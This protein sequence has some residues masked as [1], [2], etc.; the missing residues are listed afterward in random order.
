MPQALINLKILLPYQIFSENSQVSRV[1]AETRDGSFGILPHRLDCVAAL[2]PGILT[3][4]IQSEKEKYV[5]IDEGILIK[6]GLEVQV[7]VRIAFG[8]TDLAELR[9]EVD[10]EFLDLNDQEKSVRSILAKMEGG[11]MRRLAEFQNG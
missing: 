3:F 5:A 1:V 11:F 2:S 8:G 6:T 9:K 10:R 4:Q 7:S